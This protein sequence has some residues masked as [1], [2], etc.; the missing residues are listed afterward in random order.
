MWMTEK[1]FFPIIEKKLCIHL[2]Q[3]PLDFDRNCVKNG[4]QNYSLDIKYPSDIQG[5]LTEEMQYG[6]I[7][8]PYE[9]NPISN[10]HTSPFMTRDKQCFI[11][12]KSSLIC[13]GRK[14]F[15]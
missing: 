6:A 8:G 3:F 12:E 2:I 13:Y 11:I 9:V 1:V 10:C 4:N 5:I 7:F 15:Q 14:I